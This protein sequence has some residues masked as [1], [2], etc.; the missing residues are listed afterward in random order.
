MLVRLRHGVTHDAMAGWFGV[1]CS[2]S[3][4]ANGEVRPLLDEQG[5]HRQSRRA[6]AVPGRGR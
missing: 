4:R 6:A 2:T 5:M 1:D 3:T